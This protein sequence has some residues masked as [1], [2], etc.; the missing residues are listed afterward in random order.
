[1]DIDVETLTDAALILAI[2]ASDV[3]NYCDHA[4]HCERADIK[5]VRAAGET[6][7]ATALHL[8]RDADADAIELYATRLTMIEARNVLSHPGSYDGRGAALAAESW[9]G[10]QLVQVEHDR[11]YHPDII[12]LPKAEQ[13]RHYTLHVAKLTGATA[14]VLR[15]EVTQQDWLSRRVADMLL[16]GLK[17]ATV[18][19]QKLS[20]ELLPQRAAELPAITGLGVR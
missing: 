2:A 20:E 11:A 8:A 1:M 18:S 6:L 13:L 10:L 9:R 16:F 12:G 19:G 4:E 17:L 15:E 14:A 3:A 5:V 7:R